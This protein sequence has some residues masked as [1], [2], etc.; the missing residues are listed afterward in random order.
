M[1]HEDKLARSLARLTGLK[2]N[3]AQH[4]RIE[5]VF[6]DEYHAILDELKNL[7]FDLDE[8]RIPIELL[9]HRV[10]SRNVVSGRKT[11]SQTRSI[12]AD[13]FSSKLDGLLMYFQL[14]GTGGMEPITIGFS[15]PRK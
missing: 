2:Q 6:V 5:E 9:T 14:Q 13:Y 3:L 1:A 11:Y 7:G 15:A 12:G 10:T 8:F 4:Q